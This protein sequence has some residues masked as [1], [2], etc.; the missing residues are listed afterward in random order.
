MRQE[1]KKQQNLSLH[2]LELD[3][4][5]SDLLKIKPSK[6]EQKKPT[7]EFIVTF[8]CP[9]PMCGEQVD[10]TISAKTKAGAWRT[11][12]PNCG[13]HEGLQMEP[14]KIIEKSH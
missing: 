3:E 4:A 12:G 10:L 13:H 11:G 7:K 8:R 1:K 6:E 14:K 5:V 9:S 2:P